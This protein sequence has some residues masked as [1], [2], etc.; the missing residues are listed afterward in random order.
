M[1][2][3]L[4][5]YS[6]ETNAV[7]LYHSCEMQKCISFVK[8]NTRMSGKGRL[9]RTHE[10][11]NQTK[12]TNHDNHNAHDAHHSRP[13]RCRPVVGGLVDRRAARVYL[14]SRPDTPT[15]ALL[16]RHTHAQHSLLSVVHHG[17][18]RHEGV[19][20]QE[21][22]RL[23]THLLSHRDVHR[24]DAEHPVALALGLHL[25]EV[26][27]RRNGHVEAIEVVLDGGPVAGGRTS[28][29]HG[30]VQ[31]VRLAA[32]RGQVGVIG[33]EVAAQ[34][35][36]DLLRQDRQRRARV[37]HGGIRLLLVSLQGYNNRS[38]G[39]SVHANVVQMHR[40]EGAALDVG[41][42]DGARG[43][44]G[45]Q[46]AHGENALRAPE[47]CR[48]DVLRSLALVLGHVLVEPHGGLR[49]ETVVAVV[50]PAGESFGILIPV[51]RQDTM[52]KLED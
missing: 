30:A 37:E 34:R 14:L 52:L 4:L 21:V 1:A 29:H 51:S 18:S 50:V 7:V 38:E 24:P 46:I 13:A 12:E 39:V 15:R 6:C 28:Q 23:T 40:V 25:Q 43:Q 9:V 27:G 42:V 48:E 8:T 41:V 35:R 45:V 11:P 32:E 3:C 36:E 17:Q 33:H 19:S 16:S 31:H 22:L 47:A 20:Q 26:H 10:P 44:R 2:V 5:Y 49:R